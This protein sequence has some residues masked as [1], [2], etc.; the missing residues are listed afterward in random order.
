[1]PSKRDIARSGRNARKVLIVLNAGILPKPASPTAKLNKDTYDDDD[2]GDEEG[3]SSVQFCIIHRQYT[4]RQTY[5][6][7]ASSFNFFLHL[8]YSLSLSEFLSIQQ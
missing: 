5:P 7:Y 6:L 2:V 8:S 3:V 4:C 1:M